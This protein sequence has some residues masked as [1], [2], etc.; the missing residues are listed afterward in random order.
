MAIVGIG[1]D[2]V[3]LARFERV[4]Q[5]TP[6]IADRL[7]TS[8]EQTSARGHVLATQSLAGRFAVKEAV[9]KALGAPAGM[10]FH[11]CQVSNGG[12]PTITLSGTVA[13]A[14]R[15]Q[16]VAHWHVSISHDGPVAVAYVIA[17]S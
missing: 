13:A 9:A 4:L 5:R 14:A 1:V 6:A 15:Q 8:N 2:V 10:R 16:G 17:E 7:F 11:D 3:D 12:R